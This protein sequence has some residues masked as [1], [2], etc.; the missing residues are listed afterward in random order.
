MSIVSISYNQEEYIREALDGF[1]AQRTEFPVE[2]IIADDAST[3]ATPRIIGEYAARYPQLFRPI[4]R[5]TN[6]G[7]HANFKDVLSAARGEYLALCEGDDYWTDPLKLS[8]QV[9]YLDR[10]PETTVCFHPVRVIYEDGAKDSEFPPLSWRRDLSVDALLARNFIQTNSVVYRRLE[11][12]DDIPADVMPLDWYLHV[13]HAVHGDI[14]MLPDTMA[15]YRRHAQ[16]MWHNQVVDPPKFWLTQGPGHAATFDAMLDL[17]PGDPAREELIAVMADWILRQIA[18]VPGPEGRAALQ[19]TIA[20]HPRIAMLAL[21]HRGAT[22]ARRLKTQWRKLAAATPSRRG[23]VD[24][25]PSRLRRG[26]R[27]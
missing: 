17:F 27:A 25:W 12:Y 10:H 2:V 6:I 23:L 26:C 21:Q 3:D 15:V 5:Q 14:A 20:R 11:R 7:V 16:G 1:A 22:P 24:V 9:K 4:L 19:E 8:K 18:N 13:R